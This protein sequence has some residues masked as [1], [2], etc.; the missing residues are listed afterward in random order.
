M[1][2]RKFSCG[3]SNEKSFHIFISDYKLDVS[4]RLIFAETE[5]CLDFDLLVVSMTIS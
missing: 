3:E 4:K 5:Y 1:N 2:A